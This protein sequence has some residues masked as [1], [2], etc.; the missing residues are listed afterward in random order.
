LRGINEEVLNDRMQAWCEDKTKEEAL[1]IFDTARIPSS[2]LLSPQE[3]LDDPHVRAMQYIKMMDFPGAPKPAPVIE[4]PFRMSATPGSIRTRAP[5]LG[6][7]TDAVLSALG[8]DA[9]KIA[10]LRARSII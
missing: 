5:L 8:Y 6:E 3:A 1:R 7:H 9:A 2:P 4:T 10:D